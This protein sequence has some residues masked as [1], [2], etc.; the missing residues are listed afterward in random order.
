MNFF[1][2]ADFSPFIGFATAL[3]MGCK[4]MIMLRHCTVIH[5]VVK[6][7]LMMMLILSNLLGAAYC[8]MQFSWTIQ[9]HGDEFNFWENAGWFVHDW[10][11]ALTNLAINMVI[12]ALIK[13]KFESVARYACGGK[14]S[15]CVATR[16]L[17]AKGVLNDTI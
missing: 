3:F 6:D 16:A 13:H 11:N 7:A 14:R 4:A 8:I 5:P 1:A 12:I 15:D 10:L 9:G 2:F 17:Q